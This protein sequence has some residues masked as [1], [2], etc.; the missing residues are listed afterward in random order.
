MESKQCTKCKK[1]LLLEEFK[2]NDRTGQYTQCCI[3]CLDVC[4]KY[5]EKNKCINK[6]ARPQC[7]ECGGSQICEHT[8]IRST[9]KDCG[10]TSICEHYKIR[11]TC[12]DCG[13]NQI[14]IHGKQRSKCKECGGGSICQHGKI[15]S[16]CK[17]CGGSQIWQ[18]GKIRSI[19][20]ECGGGSTCQHGTRR[21]ICK[22]CGGS[23]ICEHNKI[24]H[25]CQ[26]CD[27][28]GHLPG[29]VRSRIYQALKHNKTMHSTEYTQCTT[30]QLR[31][32]LEAQFKEGMMWNNYGEWHVD[33]RIPLAYKQDGIPPTLEEVIERC[34]YANTQPLWASEYWSKGNRYIALNYY[35]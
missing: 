4:K 9:C 27:L 21:S 31:E 3:K 29:C 18:H 14:C 23:Q 20:K 32:H 28:I 15:R 25:R 12:K 1:V 7:K 19:C 6:R 17:G 26:I 13:G 24:R 22:E 34:H 2:V 8:K 16:K 5:R 30:E 11:P 10:G 35:T 33:H